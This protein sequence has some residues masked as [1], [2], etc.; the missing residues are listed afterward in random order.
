[1]INAEIARIFIES[2]IEEMSRTSGL[3]S[4]MIWSTIAM[5]P[6]GD[7]ANRFAAYLALVVAA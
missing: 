3:S 5:D 6:N 2:A 1:M 7:C 4:A